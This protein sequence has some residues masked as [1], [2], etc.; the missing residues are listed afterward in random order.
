MG[1]LIVDVRDFTSVFQKRAVRQLPCMRKVAL[2]GI[3]LCGLPISSCDRPLSS[4]LMVN[5][6]GHSDLLQSLCNHGRRCT[7]LGRIHDHLA[8]ESVDTEGINVAGVGDPIDDFEAMHQATAE[9]E[10]RDDNDLVW[11]VADS[12]KRLVAKPCGGDAMARAWNALLH[13][14]RW[15]T[16]LIDRAFELGWNVIITASRV[17]GMENGQFTTCSPKHDC[18]NSFVCASFQCPKLIDGEQMN[19]SFC[20]AKLLNYIYGDIPLPYRPPL[21]S[22]CDTSSV[23]T[24]RASCPSDA[25]TMWARC[26][27]PR[28][29]RAN[30]V[31]VLFRFGIAHTAS[32]THAWQA[33]SEAERFAMEPAPLRIEDCEFEI[34]DALEDPDQQHDLSTDPGFMRSDAAI[35]A[36]T[37]AQ[38][39]ARERDIL[40]KIDPDAWLASPTSGLPWVVRQ[41]LPPQTPEVCTC[42][43]RAQGR[44]EP[45]TMPVISGAVTNTSRVAEYISPRNRELSVRHEK[46]DLHVGEWLLDVARRRI[47]VFE[48]K[49]VIAIVVTEVPERRYPPSTHRAKRAHPTAASAEATQERHRRRY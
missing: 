12:L 46:G 39:Y 14:D 30:N 36:L 2:R 31:V 34:F 27:V 43:V 47:Y 44:P 9:M 37:Q 28:S 6:T 17:S 5:K 8:E 23:I 48:G 49:V 24:S 3:T 11:V 20:V 4:L 32:D 21:T 25:N 41:Q 29:D 7:F 26:V 35:A 19:L 38:T 45:L 16:P 1:V 40:L 33:A 15:L 42:F 22:F 18:C 13:V 10:E